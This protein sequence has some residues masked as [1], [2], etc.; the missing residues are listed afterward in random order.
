ASGARIDME[1]YAGIEGH[2]RLLDA[3]AVAHARVPAGKRVVV[4]GGGKIGLVLAESL[5][6]SG[7]EVTIV[8]REKRIAG[9]VMPTFKWRH[10]TWVEELGIP[11]HVNSRLKRVTEQG[12]V[13]VDA[14]GKETLLEADSVIAA[15]PRKANQE[16]FT[17]F[18]WMV[19]ELHGCGDALMP[20]G[21]DAAIHEGYR[22]GVR[23]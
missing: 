22:L 8:E 17:D 5:R 15:G 12:A 21:L 4:I 18:E 23:V 14:K 1:A 20:R 9:D 7:A 11:V 6:K 10:T 13:I 16:L 19:D 3:L 2:E